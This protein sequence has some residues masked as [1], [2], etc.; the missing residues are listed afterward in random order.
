M[1]MFISSV[2]ETV[3]LSFPIYFYLSMFSELSSSSKVGNPLP[4]IDSFFSIYDD[5][6]RS[7]V[8]AESVA[9]S[10]HSEAPHLDTPTEES[11]SVSLWVEAAL[12]TDLEIVSLIT[13]QENGASST[14]QKS[15]SKR[16]SF[17]PLSQNNVKPCSPLPQSNI[18]HAGAWTRG[19]GMQNTVE[20][21][22]QLQS[23]MKMWFLWFVEEALDAGFRVF[24][25][26]A[27]DGGK[28]PLDSSSITAVLS[29]LKRVN[30]WLDRV[31]SRSDEPLLQKVDQLKR[32]IYGFV[33][34]HV[35]TTFDNPINLA[36][37]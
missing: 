29:Q 9:N 4:T 28:L 17:S 23:E 27:T 8:N 34:Q 21:G 1:V 37:S 7:T 26:C 36:S 20:L 22:N 15:L 31:V 5:V 19:H 25:E 33:I 2:L 14:L 30:E 16:Q 32:K 12:A 10:R 18:S 11:R 13:S 3:V 35:G 6:M 24:G